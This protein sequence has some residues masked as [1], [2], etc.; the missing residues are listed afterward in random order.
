MK[1]LPKRCPVYPAPIFAQMKV[2]VLEQIGDA[3]Y[4]LLGL[5]CTLFDLFYLCCFVTQL[6]HA[7][8]A[9]VHFET[10]VFRN[11]SIDVN[12]CQDDDTGGRGALPLSDSRVQAAERVDMSNKKYV[13]M[14]IM[15]NRV[16]V[17]CPEC[18]AHLHPLDIKALAG[19]RTDLIEK[20][21]QF[22]VRRYLMTE[23]DARW[24]PAPDC[25]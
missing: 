16:E 23:P 6:A 25:G 13:E 24:C 17:S 4:R 3:H 2:L 7:M 22:S 12:L 5:F 14:E 11:L 10:S 9:D 8:C 21:E 15:E 1:N 18:A 20:Y 19:G